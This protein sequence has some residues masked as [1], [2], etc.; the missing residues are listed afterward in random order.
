MAAAFDVLAACEVPWSNAEVASPQETQYRALGFRRT[1]ASVF[2]SMVLADCATDP[3]SFRR[4]LSEAFDRPCNPKSNLSTG[5]RALCKHYE[6]NTPFF[7]ADVGGDAGVEK[8]PP[9]SRVHA[10]GTIHP[11]WTKPT[12]SDTEKNS[13]AR[14]HLD[15]LLDLVETNDLYRCWK[16]IHQIHPHDT[17][18][19]E[20]RETAALYGMRWTLE[21]DGAAGL[22]GM[23]R[24]EFRGFVEP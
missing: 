14:A 20:A 6:R 5:A 23:Y 8:S 9:K 16:N 24:A 1:T 22:D 10:N 15:A 2:P 11:F 13:I 4:I 7:K 3:A 17:T 21:F 12:G 18:I 19:F